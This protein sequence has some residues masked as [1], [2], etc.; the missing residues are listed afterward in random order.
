MPEYGIPAEGERHLRV[1]HA[2]SVGGFVLGLASV[3]LAL[4]PL[5]GL[6]CGIVGIV[7]SARAKRFAQERGFAGMATAGLVL[8]V[9]GTVLGVLATLGW[10]A[11]LVG[12][13]Y[14]YDL[15]RQFEMFRG[16]P[17]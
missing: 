10:A 2:E 5:V 12:V 7:L 17:A 14:Q 9:I 1:L 4:V 13:N 16:R 6:A 3:L 8:S 11:A 15:Q